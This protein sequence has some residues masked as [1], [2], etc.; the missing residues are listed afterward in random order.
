MA[1]EA[2]RLAV[3]GPAS[4]CN[5]GMRIK[6]LLHIDVALLNELTEFGHLAD[7][8]ESKH[9]ILLVAIDGHTSRV[10][11][12][13]FKSCETCTANQVSRRVHTHQEN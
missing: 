10:I 3:S 4:V 7:L 2:G 12:A 11:A 8:L 6:D 13:V 5:A 1:V 9:L